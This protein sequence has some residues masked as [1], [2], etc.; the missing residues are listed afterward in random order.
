[1]SQNLLTRL[2]RALDEARIPYMIIGGQAVLLYG[3][4]RLTRD[5]DVTVGLTS[6]DVHQVLQVVHRV[7]LRLLVQ[8]VENFV[9]RTWVLPALDEE[10]G[11]RVDFVFSWTPYEQ[12]ALKRA[13]EVTVEGYPVRFASPEDVI[14]H[15]VLAG[16]PRDLEDVR[17]ILR[18]QTLDIDYIRNWLRQFEATLETDYTARFEDVLRSAEGG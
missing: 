7:A 16:R 6:H 5:V 4:P 10:T 11:L 13:R 12:E 18:K 9:Q 14:I 2:A 1:M 15:K 17:S 3:E 8:D